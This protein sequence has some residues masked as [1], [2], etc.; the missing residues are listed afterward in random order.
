MK[1][2]YGAAV[3]THPAPAEAAGA[4]IGEVI[5]QAGL[6]PSVALLFVSGDHVAAFDDIAAAVRRTLGPKVMAGASA[7]SVIGGPTEVEDT[8][9]V[10]LWAAALEGAEPALPVRL[11]AV[12]TPDGAELVGMPAEA[13]R[14]D[15]TLVLTADPYTFPADDLM[16]HAAERYPGLRIIG[17]L[18][19]AGGPGSNRLALDGDVFSDGA[20]GVLL[21]AGVGRRFVVS[22]GC[23]PVGAPYTVTASEG[24]VVGELGGRPA[25]VRLVDLVRAAEPGERELLSRGLHIGMVIDEH[26]DSFGPN[27]FLIRSV[28]GADR[29]TGAVAI[30]GVVPVG[31]TL[32]YHVRDR[33]TADADLRAMLADAG[34]AGALVFT[35]NGRGVNLFGEP[36]H[37]AALVHEAT[38]GGAVAG[39]FCAGEMGPVAGRN[40]VHGFT[41]SV[42]LFDA[43]EDDDGGDDGEEP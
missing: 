7:V 3:S 23:R 14:P 33:T 5:E 39:M 41:A 13:S 18:A 28:L 11:E 32:Q 24:N 36:H 27:D 29:S 34:G 43:G 35:C 31:S 22:Q 30:G 8:A 37:D 6:L 25:L 21:P 1:A 10:S 2:R 40:H 4:V 16:D 38:G 26:R 17:G 42:L 12:T 20:A 19:S 9:G 15:R